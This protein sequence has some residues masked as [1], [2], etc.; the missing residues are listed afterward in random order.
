MRG[1]DYKIAQCHLCRRWVTKVKVRVVAR[2]W[3]R[4]HRTVYRFCDS[5]GRQLL[6]ILQRLGEP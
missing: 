5:C 3:D 4:S 2:L 6:P 1:S